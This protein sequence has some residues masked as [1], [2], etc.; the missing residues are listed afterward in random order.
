[1]R[2]VNN[3]IQY[4]VYTL[5]TTRP[6]Q[7]NTK[8]GS[9]FQTPSVN[10]VIRHLD[11]VISRY[12]DGPYQIILGMHDDPNSGLQINLIISG[13]KGD[14]EKLLWNNNIGNLSRHFGLSQ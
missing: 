13:T 8:L 14:T 5:R 4:N 2:N 1:M 9:L 10:T 7:M 3:T 6:W 12:M 11:T